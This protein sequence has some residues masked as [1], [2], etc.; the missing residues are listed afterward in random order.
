MLTKNQIKA[1]VD[2]SG[3]NKPGIYQIK[4]DCWINDP[5]I[6]VK[7]IEPTLLNVELQPTSSPT[8]TE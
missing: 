2:I 5:K 4:V 1:F 6:N 8:K 7:F 3:Y